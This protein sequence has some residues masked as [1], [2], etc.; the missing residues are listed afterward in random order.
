MGMSANERFGCLG[1]WTRM[2]FDQ[3]ENSPEHG[4]WVTTVVNNRADR[5]ARSEVFSRILVH[6]VQADRHVLIGKNLVGL[7]GYI[8]SEREIY[9]DKLFGQEENKTGEKLLEI[10]N[11]ESALLR[12][13]QNIETLDQRL[14]VC[15]QGL[16]INL[17]S[18]NP[19]ELKMNL[20][21]KFKHTD[22]LEQE[23]Y[24]WSIHFLETY[25]ELEKFR[26]EYQNDLKKSYSIQPLSKFLDRVF[27][28]KIVVVE[29]ALA[30]GDEINKVLAEATPPGFY[31]K[32]MGMQNIKGTGLDFVYRW[33]AW[34]LIYRWGQ[35]LLGDDVTKAYV[36]IDQLLSFQEYGVL[37][38]EYL[39]EVIEKALR[40]SHTQNESFQAMLYRLKSKHEAYEEILEKSTP[41]PVDESFIKKW[42]NA[43][44]SKFEPLLDSGDAVRRRK[45]ADQIYD[46]LIF[47]R[48]SMDKA[49]LELKKLTKRQKGGWLVYK[50]D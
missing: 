5:I 50:G 6:D 32:C 24:K 27:F 47:E 21:E 13:P 2:K 16:K 12:M 1:N 39:P 44:V 48:I 38:R 25:I 49:S 3:P 20:E 34:E 17:D 15:S 26:A 33:Q 9:L 23:K 22:G 42:F 29:D 45:Q 41:D 11:Q 43:V 4:V 7:M 46:D 19:M 37:D 28:D 30:T 36:A 35:D 14:K 31:N 8:E 40:L 10:L 18:L